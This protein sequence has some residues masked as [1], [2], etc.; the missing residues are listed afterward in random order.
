MTLSVG[1][2]ATR[3]IVVGC[4]LKENKTRSEWISKMAHVEMVG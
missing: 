4:L 2:E 3:G 1:F